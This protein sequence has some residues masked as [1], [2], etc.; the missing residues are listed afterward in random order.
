MKIL[1]VSLG[2]DKNLVDSEEMLGSLR[3]HHFSLTNEETEADVIVVNTCCFIDDAKQESIDTILEMAAYKETGNLKGLI[4][5]GCLAQ[6][7]KDEILKEIPE[8]DAILGTTAYHE[9]AQAVEAVLAGKGYQSFYSIDAAPKTA[10]SRMLTTGG[11]YAYLKISEGCN[12]NC[13][14]CIIP[15]VRGRFRSVPMEDL[16]HQA[17]SLVRQGV[18]ELIIVAQESTMYGTDLYGEKRLHQL[19]RELVKIEGLVWLRVLYAYPEEIYDELIEVMATEPKICNYLDLPIQHAS[20]RVLRRMGRRTSKAQLLAKIALL[21]ERIPN[22]CLRTTLISG[23]PSETGE[24]HEE[25]KQFIQ[26]V[27]FD[28]LGVFAYSQEEDTAAAKMPDQIDDE[29]KQDRRNAL[30]ELQKEISYRKGQE[31]IGRELMI[32]VEG[33]IEDEEGLPILIGRSYRD[34][35]NVDGYVFVHDHDAALRFMTGDFVKVRITEAS[36][37]DLF[38]E[39]AE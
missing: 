24:E 18:K 16:L 10:P 22:I 37:Y 15:K 4:A 14:Y 5:T 23:F 25:A 8:V 13:S 28:R 35:P 33:T 38:G 2:C 30:M 6:R 3:S 20:D 26:E 17:E 31:Q 29:I 21:R 32:I 27:G 7:Y 36:E 9:I 12:K 34:V 19:C 11:H 1:F 39:V